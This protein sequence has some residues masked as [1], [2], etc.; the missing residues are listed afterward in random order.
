MP[1]TL[2]GHIIVYFETFTSVIVL[3]VITG[4]PYVKFSKPS[5]KLVRFFK[6]FSSAPQWIPEFE[7]NDHHICCYYTLS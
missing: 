6:S 5:A 7:L 4:V 2:W 1:H 3:A